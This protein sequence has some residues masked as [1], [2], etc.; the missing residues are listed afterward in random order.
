MKQNSNSD[1]PAEYDDRHYHQRLGIVKILLVVFPGTQLVYV[2]GPALANGGLFYRIFQSQRRLLES[3]SKIT[4]GLKRSQ[5]TFGFLQ[6]PISNG[7]R[8][9]KFSDF[10]PK[11]SKLKG[12]LTPL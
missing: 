10:A 4:I 12:E 11:S 8:L 5:Q 7:L 1:D 9:A 6:L 2:Q 3:S